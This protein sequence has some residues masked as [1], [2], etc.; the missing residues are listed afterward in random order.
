MDLFADVSIILTARHTTQRLVRANTPLTDGL[1][2]RIDCSIVGEEL[3]R[4]HSARSFL[5]RLPTGARV[6]LHS[7]NRTCNTM[8]VACISYAARGTH[9]VAFSHSAEAI[10]KEVHTH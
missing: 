9:E 2:F 1:N 3:P 4:Q 8:A 5:W 6:M 10:Q 7:S